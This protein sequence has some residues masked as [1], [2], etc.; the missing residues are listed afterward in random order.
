MLFSHFAFSNHIVAFQCKCNRNFI[1]GEY[2]NIYL[3]FNMEY[4]NAITIVNKISFREY[5]AE[6]HNSIELHFSKYSWNKRCF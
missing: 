3:M 4:A 1:S 5:S 6:K 2:L